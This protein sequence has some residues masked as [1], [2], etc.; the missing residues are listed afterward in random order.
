MSIGPGT[1]SND[2]YARMP[3]TSAACGLIGTTVYPLRSRART[4]RLPNLCRSF[5]APITATTFDISQYRTPLVRVNPD[6]TTA[7]RAH[8]GAASR[9]HGEEL[10]HPR[11]SLAQRVHRRRVRQP[12]ESRRIECLA[13]R[14]RHTRLAQ[15]R[16]GELGG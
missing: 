12:D 8:G 13:R 4:A 16:L 6:A 7:L 15:Q 2:A 3:S 9:A 10:E 1:S 11:T 14:H 5:D